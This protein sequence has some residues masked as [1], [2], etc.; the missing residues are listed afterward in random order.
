MPDLIISTDSEV[1]FNSVGRLKPAV[2]SQVKD[3]RF[4]GTVWKMFSDKVPEEGQV[5]NLYFCCG[6]MYISFVLLP[7]FA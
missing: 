3:E 6:L 4:S 5:R 1:F 2:S 7:S